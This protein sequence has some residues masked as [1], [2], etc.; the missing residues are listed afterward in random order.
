MTDASV[1]PPNAG[2]CALCDHAIVRPT[3]RGTVYLR[4]GRAA[5]D[6][7]FPRYPTLPVRACPGFERADLA[8][9]P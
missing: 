6:S 2:L 1:P 3:R 7:R 4:C 5:D 9:E 8:R